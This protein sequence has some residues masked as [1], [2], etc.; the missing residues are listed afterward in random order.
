VNNLFSLAIVVVTHLQTFR[1][2]GG[3]SVVLLLFKIIETI[4]DF[5]CFTHNWISIGIS[6]PGTSKSR[7]Y[8]Q[9]SNGR[10]DGSSVRDQT[11]TV[12]FSHQCN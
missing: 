5:S 2:D 7:T 11:Y 8:R 12:Y 4:L 6:T 1:Q 10:R 9:N 3:F